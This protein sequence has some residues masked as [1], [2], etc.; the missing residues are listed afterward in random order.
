LN[1]FTLYSAEVP[2]RFHGGPADVIVPVD[3]DVGVRTNA[4][5]GGRAATIT[6]AVLA[7]LVG[8]GAVIHSHAH[9]GSASTGSVPVVP[10]PPPLVSNTAPSP[11]PT[12]AP[13]RIAIDL[14]ARS[15]T[16]PS[17]IWVVVNKTHPI[18]PLDFTP[19]IAIV[20]GYR[21]ARSAAAPLAQL[22]NAGDA[23][24]LGLKIE[25][26]FRSYGYQV[27]IHDGAVASDGDAGA[28]R[29]SARAGYSEHQTGL[30]VDLISLTD[31]RCNMQACFASTRAGRWLARNAWRYGFIVRYLPGH[32][33]I[34]G[35]SPEPWHIRFVGRPLAAA[36]R[37]AGIS[38]L[39]QVFHIR[40]G[41]YR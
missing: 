25:S 10:P 36:M 14:K 11:A 15:I 29:T 4:R 38:T 28:D 12:P 39:E 1:A 37:D 7:A 17:S 19:A 35:Y 41:G 40:G 2:R 24:R 13:P 6:L 5:I 31:S 3:D 23:A 27:S 34:T 16:D 9:S 20:R 32:R 22:L 30:A 26:G 8:I 33:H 21:V 18:R